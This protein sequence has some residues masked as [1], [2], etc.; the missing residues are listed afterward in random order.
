VETPTFKEAFL[1]WLKLGFISFGGPAGQIAI[2]HEELVVRKKWIDEEHFHSALSFCML[3]PG[4]EAQQLATYSG[5]LLHGTRGGLAAGILFILP[6]IFILLGLSIVYVTFGEYPVAADILYFLRPAVLGII[7]FSFLRLS[8]KSVQTQPQ[9]IAAFIAFVG[10]TFFNISFPWLILAALLAG[11][12]IPAKTNPDTA[13]GFT[14]PEKMRKH[15]SAKVL[16]A[17]FLLLILPMAVVVLSDQDFRFWSTLALFFTKAAC[18]TFGG[19]YAVLPYVA[20]VSVNDFGWLTQ[21]QMID[22]LALGET[23]P[24]PLIMVLAF[25]G[26]MAGFQQSMGSI[27]MGTAG[28]LI[29]VWYTFLPGF[30]FVFLGAPFVQ[31][32]SA[33]ARVKGVLK[34][35]GA[36]VA[37]VILNLAWTFGKSVLISASLNVDLMAVVIC[38]VVVYIMHK[39]LLSVPVLVAAVAAAGLVFSLT[40]H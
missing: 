29:T 6:S 9:V 1:F 26:F 33:S 8:A 40:T 23:T 4:P 13:T 12:F 38:G 34:M 27:I 18:I 24:G 7:I 17:G 39:K 16:A 15:N 19:A 32:F 3:L 21:Q 20:D 37:G 31:R 5:W 28:L 25:V 36:T 10:M 30:I 35:V 2:M 14:A 11:W 22:G